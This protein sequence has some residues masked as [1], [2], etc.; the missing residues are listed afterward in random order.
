[1]DSF[2]SHSSII[3]MGSSHHV[4]FVQ[5]T[6]TNFR[7]FSI[8]FH[9]SNR[10]AAADSL[11]ISLVQKQAQKRK[12]RIRGQMPFQLDLKHML[13]SGMCYHIC[14]AHVSLGT[15]RDPERDPVGKQEHSRPVSAVRS[16]KA[17]SQKMSRIRNQRT[18]TR[19]E[20]LR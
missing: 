13:R 3:L 20:V 8:H 14:A 16:Q 5:K 10:Q 19:S 4:I 2:L 15:R 7:S 9:L 11:Q 18:P 1:M 17:E 12:K 6:K